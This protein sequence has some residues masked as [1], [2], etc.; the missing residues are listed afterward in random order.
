MLFP[1]LKDRLQI[2]GIMPERALLRLRRAQ[3]PLYNVK[4]I[5][6]NRILFRVKRKDVEKIFAIYPNICYNKERKVK[7]KNLNYLGKGQSLHLFRIR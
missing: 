1:N 6:K 3:I 5:A 4:K 2:E 7:R